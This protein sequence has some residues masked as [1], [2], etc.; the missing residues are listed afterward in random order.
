[1]KTTFGKL[2]VGDRF[3][4]YGSL[5]TRLDHR[6]ARQHSERSIQLGPDGG[7]YMADTI[8]T[9]TTEEA[10]VFVPPQVPAAAN[11]EDLL[12]PWHAAV[13][14]EASSLFVSEYGTPHEVVKRVI[15]AHVQVA[16]DPQVSNE[17]QA[18]VDRGA[19][20]IVAA[21]RQMRELQR[22]YFKTRARDT[23]VASKEAEREFDRLLV[24]AQPQE[25]R[26]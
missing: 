2:W 25:E 11:P 21:G 4:A 16:L 9:F 22:Q 13:I 14:E 24:A 1:M 20:P 15:A 6:T 5:W 19:Q 3:T 8:C 12:H 7:G 17:A 26:P 23:L 10:V 18:L